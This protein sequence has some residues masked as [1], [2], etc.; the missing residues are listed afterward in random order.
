MSKAERRKEN[1]STFV[2]FYTQAGTTLLVSCTSL[3]LYSVAVMSA[4]HHSSQKCDYL[5]IIR[6]RVSTLST[7]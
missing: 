5:L 3:P 2:H 7:L 4:A 6:G 1:N